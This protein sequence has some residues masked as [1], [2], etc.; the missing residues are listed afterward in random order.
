MYKKYNGRRGEKVVYLH[1]SE[2]L[3][4]NSASLPIF[5]GGSQ[6]MLIFLLKLV[7]LNSGRKVVYLLGNIP[8]HIRHCLEVKASA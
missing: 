3:P 8:E 2:W 5:S 6:V 7:V 4:E 1:F